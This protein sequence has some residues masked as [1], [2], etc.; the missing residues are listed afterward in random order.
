MTVETS[1]GNRAPALLAAAEELFLRKG[2]AG[3]TMEQVSQR[4]GFSKRTVYLYF[5]N[6]DEL[7]LT[8]VSGAL[9]R[10]QASL[11]AIPVAEMGFEE[12]IGAVTET[13]IRF[14]TET[15]ESFQ[16]VFQ[17]ASKEML[18]N[19]SEPVRA[20]VAAHE[21]A[22]LAVPA[23]VVARG[24]ADGLV[25]PVDPQEAAIVFWGSVTG[26]ILLSLGGS[27]TV[28]PDNRFDIIR[29]A[30]WVLYHGYRNLPEGLWGDGDARARGLAPPSPDREGGSA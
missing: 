14:A 16:F 30:V 22:C 7:F 23:R 5:K 27:Q 24:V 15:P 25:P 29:R 20:R 3:T 8:V 28:L 19:V 18:A 11:E 26:I 13:Y 17:Q 10:L 1:R 12:A 4:C 6:K 9:E 21:R 2:H